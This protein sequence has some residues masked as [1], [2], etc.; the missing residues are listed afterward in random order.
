MSCGVNWRRCAVAGSPVVPKAAVSTA[1]ST[2][3]RVMRPFRPVP[4]MREA[5]IP[6]CC[7]ARRT[8]GLNLVSPSPL[9]PSE[10]EGRLIGSVRA[11]TSLG[12]NGFPSPS[13]ILPKSAPGTASA[14]LSSKTSTSTPAAGDGTSWVTLSVSS[15]TSGSLTA[16]ASPT[17]FSH[18]RTTALVP[19][20]SS[21]TRT[22]II[23]E[24]H[25]PLDFGTDAV[26]GRQGGF[27]Q[28]RMMRTRE[29][30][31][32]HARNRRIEVE[33]SFVGNNR[34]DLGAEAA[35]SQVFMDDQAAASAADAVE[36]HVLVP[37]HERPKVDDIG[38]DTLGG[39]LA[40]RDHGAPSDNGDL[41]ALTGLFGTSERQ[42]IVVA[43]PRPPRPAVVE[44]GSMFEEQ[45][46]VVAA[47]RA[48]QQADRIFG[49]GRHRDLPARIMDELNLVGLAVPRVP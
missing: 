38:A 30:R 22:S 5:S 35:G 19:S 45:H 34:R 47:Q 25:Q 33:E 39:R 20:C 3:S 6:C 36:H 14:S 11:S 21:G 7:N 1:L 28:F 31:H 43:R 17:F 24:A 18:E 13:S 16:T 42:D 41:V 40:A 8:E 29:V 49:I 10:V 26:R 15:S 37:G 46:R 9:V 2:S 32:G 4:A 23:S 44:H 12:T 48:A 27:H